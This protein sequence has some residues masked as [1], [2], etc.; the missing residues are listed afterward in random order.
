M[1]S[2]TSISHALCAKET[3]AFL[4]VAPA[5]GSLI[6]GARG[7]V[8]ESSREISSRGTERPNVRFL[9]QS[10]GQQKPRKPPRGKRGKAFD[11]TAR[12][13][14]GPSNASPRFP[15]G[16][17]SSSHRGDAPLPREPPPIVRHGNAGWIDDPVEAAK[18]D[19]FWREVAEA[20]KYVRGPHLSWIDPTKRPKPPLGR[21]GK[22]VEYPAAA[23]FDGDI[24]DFRPTTE[25]EEEALRGPREYDPYFV[26]EWV[27][28]GKP[29]ATHS[30]TK[31]GPDK[32]RR[33]KAS[34]AD[35]EWVRADEEPQC[36]VAHQSV[37][38]PASPHSNE[39]SDQ[40]VDEAS[41]SGSNVETVVPPFSSLAVRI[42]SQRG[43]ASFCSGVSKEAAPLCDEMRAPEEDNRGSTVSRPHVMENHVRR[44]QRRQSSPL[45]SPNMVLH[46]V[47]PP[48][49]SKRQRRRRPLDLPPGAWRVVN[50]GTSSAVPTRKRNVSCT[51]FIAAR[52]EVASG[53]TL[54]SQRLPQNGHHESNPDDPTMFLVDA[55]ENA[56]ARLDSAY[57]CK[58]HGFRWIRAVFITHLHGDHIYGLPS[59]LQNIGRFA[60]FR[61][62]RALE[63]GDDGSDPIIRIFGP[64]GTRGFV[65]TSLYWSPPLGVR[66]SIAELVPR[67]TDFVHLRGNSSR[68]MGVNDTYH[69]VAEDE[70]PDLALDTPPPHPEEVRVDDV[71][72]DENGVWH[73]WND[74]DGSGVHVSAAPLKHRV[75]CFGYVFSEKESH[76][77]QLVRSHGNQ[78]DAATTN[79]GGLEV[80]TVQVIDAAKAKALGVHGRQYGV[81]RSGRP[82]TIK[83]TGRVIHPKDVAP[84]DTFGKESVPS[85]VEGD[86]KSLLAGDFPLPRKVVLLGDTCDSSAI[87][88]IAKDA[89]LLVHEATF[90]NALA[91]KARL[92]MHS[93]AGM[94]G[95]FAKEI[96]ARK[97]V[98]SHFSSRYEALQMAALMMESDGRGVSGMSDAT[99][100]TPAGLDENTSEDDNVDDDLTN[101]N[102]LIQEAGESYGEVDRVVAAL[103]FMEHTV[104]RWWHG[105][106]DWR[107]RTFER[108]QTRN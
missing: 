96:K 36:G 85:N 25:E 91:D 43:T 27:P 5:D 8:G 10:K 6:P 11:R 82:V 20:E 50:L 13:P 105:D 7:R 61:R 22:S 71:E 17:F 93:T 45:K 54:Y 19:A 35:K 60:Q 69:G 40:P 48:E 53:N 97:L 39:A 70:V 107:A 95:A 62:R 12:F 31:Y 72:A 103:D 26:A 87:A 24:G 92:A 46:N 101:P 106:E 84:D 76:V 4:P 63:A 75:P 32:A 66:F 37:P 78:V 89:D 58:T 94:A 73:V 77:Q 100:P 51:A 108:E 68:S 67:E 29:P 57:W 79:G 98:L 83:S 56:S 1:A 64:Y 15:R 23:V 33:G 49:S 9:C 99:I 102:V 34:G 18:D 44:F 28:G 74:D 38:T 65:R 55:G 3:S 80:G 2:T 86:W 52:S 30:V 42:L 47:E 16:D 104:F 90:T 88:K 81:L 41:D 59:L 21:D 14:N